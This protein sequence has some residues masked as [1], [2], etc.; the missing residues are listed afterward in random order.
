MHTGCLGSSLMPVHAYFFYRKPQSRLWTLELAPQVPR[1][2]FNPTHLSSLLSSMVPE[3]AAILKI[4]FR[5]GLCRCAGGH[6]LFLPLYSVSRILSISS[7]SQ[8]LF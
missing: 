3:I 4:D 7:R 6:L 8:P 1:T 2:A 5:A